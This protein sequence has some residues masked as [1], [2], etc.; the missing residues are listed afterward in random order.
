LKRGRLNS[1]K[2]FSFKNP[3][4]EEGAVE[5]YISGEASLKE[6]R[7]FRLKSAIGKVEGIMKSVRRKKT[8]TGASPIARR[9]KKGR[10]K[11]IGNNRVF[12]WGK[13]D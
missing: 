8:E 2:E 6:G 5:D 4:E 10:P 1:T 7:M 12:A 3:S 9:N 13:A 11:L